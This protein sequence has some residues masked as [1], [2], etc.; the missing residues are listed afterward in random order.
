MG[1]LERP[2]RCGVP[3]PGFAQRSA[4]KV[5]GRNFPSAGRCQYFVRHD[6]ALMSYYRRYFPWNGPPSDRR[7][8]R[9]VFAAARWSGQL[10]VADAIRWTRFQGRLRPLFG[11]ATP[12]L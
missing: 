5:P 12:K 9:S 6:F 11:G 7:S 4:P 3:I 10:I 1:L 8:R 2:R